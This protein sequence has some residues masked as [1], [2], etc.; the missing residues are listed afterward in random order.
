MSLLAFVS[1]YGYWNLEFSLKA[2]VVGMDSEP[3]IYIFIDFVALITLGTLLLKLLAG[4]A[5]CRWSTCTGA[6]GGAKE[7]GKPRDVFRSWQSTLGW[8]VQGMWTLF[9]VV[10]VFVTLVKS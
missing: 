9:Y 10:V 1:S 3:S 2:R 8:A 5:A 4:L 7:L 6:A